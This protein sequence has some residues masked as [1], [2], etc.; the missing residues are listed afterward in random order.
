MSDAHIPDDE[1]SQALALANRLLD[2]PMADP[3]DALRMLS[4]QLIRRHE[5]IDRLRKALHWCFRDA[6]W[7]HKTDPFESDEPKPDGVMF[8][9]MREKDLLLLEEKARG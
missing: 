4:R 1:R 8:T 3:D 2:E 9:L 5:E 6:Y 7:L